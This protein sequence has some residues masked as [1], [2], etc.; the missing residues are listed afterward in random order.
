MGILDFLFGKP[1]SY[2]DSRRNLPVLASGA[3]DLAVRAK[4]AEATVLDVRVGDVIT[5]DTT[6]YVVRNRH[7]YESHG[8]EWLSYH[9]VD[10]ISGQKLWIDAEDDDELE[11]AVSRSIRLELKLPMPEQIRYEGKVYHLDEHGYAKVLIESQDSTPRYSQVEYWDFCDQDEV[12][13][14]GVERWGD[15]L[16][17]SLAEEIEPYELT[18]LPA[19]GAHA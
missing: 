19:G 16:E 15:E 13:Y 2:D 10:T 9:L 6:D 3:R 1:K 8:F 14:L 11:V 5:Y 18:I 12:H 4:T 17:A 7:V